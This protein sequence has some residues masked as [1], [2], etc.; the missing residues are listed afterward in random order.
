MV[1][2]RRPCVYGAFEALHG[3]IVDHRAEEDVPLRR[4]TNLDRTGSLEQTLEKWL[5]RSALD[6]HSGR[7]A[8]FLILQAERGAHHSFGGRIHVG[9]REYHGGVLSTQLQQ[10]W[11][12]P[13]TA[14]A[15]VDAHPYRLGTGEDHAIYPGMLPEGIADLFAATDQK[16]EHS[17]RQHPHPDKSRTA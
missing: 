17:R 6:V 11:L 12:D 2:S 16:V 8:A 7:R 10:A 1:P 5:Q 15:R 4:V 13:P 14:E 3:T 9:A